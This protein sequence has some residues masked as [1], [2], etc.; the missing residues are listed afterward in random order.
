MMTLPNEIITILSLIEQHNFEAYV[1]GGCV[2][3]NLR[4]V[5]PHDY[6]ICTSATPDEIKKILCNY[7]IYDTGLKHG[8]ITAASKDDTYEI[9]TYRIDGEY[10]DNR[11]PDKIQYT[12]NLI[13]DLSRRDFTINA[14]A[15]NHIR[16]LQDPFNGK[17]DLKN[18]VIK[19][20][21]D[22]NI[23]FNEDALRILRAIRFSA[24]L[25]FLIDAN[26]VKA[27]IKNK[28]LLDNIAIERKTSEVL[29]ILE[30]ETDL[31]LFKSHF[32]ILQKVISDINELTN[33]TITNILRVN[34]IY[35]KLAFIYSECGIYKLSELK[36]DNKTVKIVYSLCKLLNIKK[37]SDAKLKELLAEYGESILYMWNDMNNLKYSSRIKEIIELNIPYRICDLAIN[38]NDL[39]D[40]N[41]KPQNIGK[42]L[43]YLIIEVRK[44]PELNKKD[45]LL[46]LCG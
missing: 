4:N 6:D 25:N 17:K 29:Q 31:Q 27:M 15:Y 33:T 30:Y 24:K 40:I 14:M 36:L 13:D 12:S 5:Q 18:K 34:N 39:L 8:T 32:I 20:V 38:G 10:S 22:P 21:G 3:D 23:R 9:T 46:Q 45:I 43:E 42:T 26:T 41:M 16:G 44:N 11:H 19:C 28:D 2:R 7:K 35:E 37:V 1:V